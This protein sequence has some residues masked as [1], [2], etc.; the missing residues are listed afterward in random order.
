MSNNNHEY[1]NPA[2]TVDML[3][4]TIEDEQLKCLMVK[5]KEEPYAGMWSLPGVFVHIDE[6]LEE[7]ALR[8]IREETNLS[9]IYFEQL[10]TFSD[11]HRDPRKRVISVAYMALVPREKLTF[12]TGE[13]TESVSLI[14]VNNLP[15]KLA[16]DHKKI[17]EYARNRIKN[18]VEY[19]DIAFHFVSEE[20]TLPY[21]QKVYEILLGKALYK[22]NFRKKI[23]T[24]IEETGESTAGDAHRPSK[25]YMRKKS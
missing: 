15:E 25:L 23:I 22:A 17:I 21:L 3:V 19:T 7:A 4:F 8:G 6:T 12:C 24:Y 1:E 20:F 11:I 9:G 13:R 2:V 16:F 5:R 18:K 10:Y 14:H